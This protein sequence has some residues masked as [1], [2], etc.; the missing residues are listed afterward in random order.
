MI[1]TL[2]DRIFPRRVIMARSQW[3]RLGRRQKLHLAWWCLRHRGLIK[4]HRWVK[5][6]SCYVLDLRFTLIE[7]IDAQ[8]L[9]AQVEP[10]ERVHERMRLYGELALS[11]EMKRAAITYDIPMTDA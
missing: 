5:S 10:P 8:P 2:T 1:V 7:A 6:S 11:Q 3:E 4:P 9:F